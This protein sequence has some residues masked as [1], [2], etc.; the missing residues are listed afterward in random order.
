M[1]PKEFAK[2]IH[3]WMQN[4]KNQNGEW[5]VHPKEF[6]PADVC[7][8]YAGKTHFINELTNLIAQA[9]EDWIRGFIYWFNENKSD[10][11]ETL[12]P[13]I[14]EVYLQKHLGN[15]D[16]NPDGKKE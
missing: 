5:A 6:L 4:L 7:C 3:N 9:K 15:P 13:E 8:D 10:S 11:I 16:F 12:H 1:T 2:K 14:W